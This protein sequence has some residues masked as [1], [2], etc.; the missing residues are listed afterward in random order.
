MGLRNLTVIDQALKIIKKR[1]GKEID[2]SALALNDE[3]VFNLFTT[4]K[5]VGIFQF[6]SSGMQE[7][8]KSLKP[9]E[10]EDLIVMNSMYRPGPM[11]NIPEY[12][13]RKHGE[14]EIRYLHPSLEE[15]L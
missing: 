12:I 3:K 9:K 13:K 10:F 5:T 7:H 15:I 14:A 11:G 2:I 6:E 8:L 1:H 4:G